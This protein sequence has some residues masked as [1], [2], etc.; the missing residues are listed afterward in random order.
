M[1]FFFFVWRV[2]QWNF[3]SAPAERF[4]VVVCSETPWLA[5]GERYEGLWVHGVA[6]KYKTQSSATHGSGARGCRQPW[7]GVMPAMLEKW[8]WGWRWPT[9]SESQRAGS[10][11]QR[12]TGAASPVSLIYGFTIFLSTA[13]W[14]YST[15]GDFKKTQ[16][17]KT[18]QRNKNPHQNQQ[19]KKMAVTL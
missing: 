19:Q 9:G 2:V 17:T 8:C 1:F 10:K 4:C 5:D 7:A 14:E 11:E 6:L 3:L 13:K 18:K 15:V 12:S 16:K